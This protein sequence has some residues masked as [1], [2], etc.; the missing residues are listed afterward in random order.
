V[1][2][3]HILNLP[4]QVPKSV[5]KRKQRANRAQMVFSLSMPRITDLDNDDADDS[6]VSAE[7]HN[8]VE[9]VKQ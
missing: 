5:L 2:S 1:F 6:F 8:H 4:K 9:E 3:T 7:K